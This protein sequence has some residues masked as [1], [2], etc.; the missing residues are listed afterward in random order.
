ML[1]G[2]YDEMRGGL[3]ERLAHLM[4]I[5]DAPR[6]GFDPPKYTTDWDYRIDAALIAPLDD[7]YT[8]RTEV[9]TSAILDLNGFV[10]AG[11]TRSLAPRDA[12]GRIA[13]PGVRIKRIFSDMTYLLSTRFGMGGAIERLPAR[14]TRA[15]F[16]RAGCDLRKPSVLPWSVEAQLFAGTERVLRHVCVPLY[17]RGIRVGVVKCYEPLH[18]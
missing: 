1:T 16:E 15:D 17:C 3:V 13:W 5:A 18:R 4:D 14:A 10:V 12:T 6:T 8:W 7:A 11:P 9:G 2:V